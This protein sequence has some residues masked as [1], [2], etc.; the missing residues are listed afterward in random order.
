VATLAY[1]G[2]GDFRPS[3]ATRAVTVTKARPS[4]A[5]TVTTRPTAGPPAKAGRASVVVTGPTTVAAP[6]GA[7]T[8]RISRP[9]AGTRTATGTLT[10]GKRSITVPKVGKGRWTVT[11]TYPGSASFGT[12]TKVRSI[13]V[14]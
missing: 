6:T 8:L 14:R 11:A 5:L 2:N 7:V 10:Y 1:A 12:A 9:G 13:V 3:K 4:L